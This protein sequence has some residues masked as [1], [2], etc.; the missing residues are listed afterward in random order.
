MYKKYFLLLLLFLP[1]FATAGVR[2]GLDALI[3][4]K[5]T[6]L[7]GNRIGLIVNQTSRTSS[8]EYGPDLFLKL[9]DLPLVALFSPEHGIE[10][11]RRAGVNSDTVEKYKGVP[12]YSLYGST[13]K[14]TPSMLRGIDV[15]IFDIQDIGVRP[16]TYL[17]TMILAME[18][19]AENKV[20]FIV[21]DR[22][23]PLGGE[24]IEG[25]IID[26]A[27]KSFVGQVPIPY[28]HGMTLGE[29]AMMAKGERWFK[30]A[31]KLKLSVIQLKGWSRSMTW[32]ETGLN[33]IAPSPNIPTF[34]SAV[35]TAMFGAI[36][37]LGVLSIGIGSDKPFLRLGS[38]LINGDTLLLIAESV[39]PKQVEVKR[40]D[41]TVPYADSTKTYSGL[42]ITLP[43]SIKSISRLY[44]PE[45]ELFS[46]LLYNAQFKHSFDATT[47]STKLM[48][49]KVTGTEKVISALQLS[50]MDNLTP[51]SI[52][53]SSWKKDEA[54]FKL[55]RQKYLLYK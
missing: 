11:L 49:E 30:S 4:A 51:I 52:V 22:P 35:G 29:L 24:R 7:K 19:A 54:A 45:F 10:G 15:L 20:E 34:E 26:S 1:S 9:K 43:R 5:A 13:R 18:A 50:S 6:L 21:L 3:D 27:L 33:W 31:D 53:I 41:F 38:R 36:G 39:L 55:K 40:A 42:E 14:P 25:N 28:I 37:E 12:V 8:G 2:T 32:N 46:G 17:S 44:G 47:M 48:F 16:Y 23:N